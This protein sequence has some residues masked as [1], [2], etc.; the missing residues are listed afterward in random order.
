MTS[1]S[2]SRQHA[3]LFQSNDKFYLQDNDSK[4]GTLVLVKHPIK[5]TK[6]L[7]VQVGRTL[8]YLHI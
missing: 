1:T 7:T 6:N 4:Y 8:I 3:V 2:V 5:V